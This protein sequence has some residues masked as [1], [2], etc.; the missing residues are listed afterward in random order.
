MAMLLLLLAL[1]GHGALAVALV[2]RMHTLVI[3]EAAL[4][5]LTYLLMVLMALVPLAFFCPPLSGE[6]AILAGAAWLR[7]SW[8]GAGYVILCW[9]S[10]ATAVLGW[11]RRRTLLRPPAI[12]RWQRSRLHDPLGAA[13]PREREQEHHR[14]TRLPG[15]QSLALDIAERGIELP[16]L[17]AALECLRIAHLSDF[18]FSGAVGRSYFQEVVRL[19]NEFSPDLAVITGDLIDNN[20]CIAW[21]PDTLGRLQARCGVYCVFG[22]HDL[23]NDVAGL[24]RALAESGLRYLGG[25]WEQTSI[26]GEPLLLAGNELPWFA[27]AAD[28]AA[29][30]A[31]IDGRR[32]LRIALSHSP[33]QLAWART[34][35]VDLLLAGHTHG[36]QVRLPWIGPI[37][38]PSR[39]GVRFA[40]GTFYAPP[41]V[42]HVT[43][44]VSAQVPIRMNCPPEI[45][46]LTL[47]AP[48]CDPPGEL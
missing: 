32:P 21:V 30:P 33:D 48:V 41:T 42:M 23:W 3:S 44:G 31:Q 7:V 39:Q 18:H 43:R 25:R 34:H 9:I 4:A 12:L 29:A 20:E 6:V 10:A 46:L 13:T 17:P 36:G 5:Q 19:C 47:H 37:L 22:N 35:D 8:L 1:A 28:L 38:S 24:R 2:N 40:S 11:L 14:I 16:R 26:D 15:N 27:P 45:C